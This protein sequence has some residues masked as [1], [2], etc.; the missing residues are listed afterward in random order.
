MILNDQHLRTDSA[1]IENLLQWYDSHKRDFPWR[2]EVGIYQTWICEVM[3]QQ[4]TMAVVVPRFEQF[5]QVLPNVEALAQVSDA[6]LRELWAGLG[7][8]ARARNL[9][10]AAQYLVGSC[11]G[12]FPQTYDDWL[13]VPGVGPYTASVIVSVCFQV[14]KGCVDGNVLRVA[15]RLCDCQSTALW[16]ETGRQAVQSC[17][18]AV[19]PPSRPGDF[20]QAM[21]ELGATVCQKQSPA[22]VRC[23]VSSF[24]LANRN[25]S[26][27]LCPP[28]K[29]RKAFL[30][31]DLVALRLVWENPSA[32]EKEKFAL[33]ERT[34]GFLSG[35]LGFP[36]F[37]AD[38]QFSPEAFLQSA[39]ASPEV[40][41]A[42]WHQGDVS[43]TI[44]RHRITLRALSI[45][46][47]PLWVPETK[48][49]LM[50]R[51]LLNR[52][53]IP[54][55]ELVWVSKSQTRQSLA[56]SLDRKIWEKMT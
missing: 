49:E 7:Y 56:T 6:T 41:S 36:L 46:L 1:W 4:T 15:A 37:R 11:G 31:V 34:D 43:H 27:R 45:R 32:E 54:A 26:V 53:S 9:R 10:S 21:M 47:N 52:Y 18:D 51:Q 16:S 38:E 14:P 22:C 28:P 13:K 20:N 12:Q 55:G 50:V 3:S 30:D 23:P 2:K 35:T 5:M 33:F 8:Y 29:P 42:Q 17:V 24:C 44:T 25:D 39:L 48:A 19:L 40:R